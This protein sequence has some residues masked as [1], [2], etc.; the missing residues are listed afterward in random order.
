[1]NGNSNPLSAKH[2]IIV[3]FDF[4]PNFGIGGRR[5]GKLAKGFAQRGIHVH[6]VKAQ[7]KDNRLSTWS[8]DV[9]SP[10]IETLDIRRKAEL[11][12][13]NCQVPIL[14][15]LFYRLAL[16]LN[17]VKEKG[18]PY[19]LAIGS[20]AELFKT[21]DHYVNSYPV[22]WIFVSGAPFNL[23]YYV[24]EYVKQRSNLRM[25]ADFR[26]PWIK[27]KNYGMPGLSD[28]RRE[29]EHRKAKHV[30]QIADVVSYPY[31]EAA[32][33]MTELG[34]DASKLFELKH[35]FDPE[36]TLIEIP[37]RTDNR[38]KLVYGGDIY[39]DSEM[40]L[41]FLASALSTLKTSNRPLYD[42]LDIRIYSSAFHKL[43]QRFS[44]FK[45]IV[46][47][48]D[49]IGK[50]IFQEIGSADWVIVLL[51][52]YN[53][54]FFTTKYFEY[55]PFK[56]PMLYIGPEGKVSKSITHMKQGLML[57]DFLMLLQNGEL[58][59]FK[60]DLSVNPDSGSLQERIDDILKKTGIIT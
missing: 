7:S 19:D 40:H 33:E 48:Q 15:K 52:E 54:D 46:L 59:E 12:R 2:I 11:D 13:F 8:E 18:T 55:L 30:F 36:D 17:R 41:G 49:S 51:S 23:V 34:M 47:L 20:R 5:W 22:E 9:K 50:R 1:M 28:E 57:N 3:N 60:V 53:K 43:T 25:W 21:L 10:L 42:Q 6:V 32:F 39:P 38:I 26:D 37:V 14:N 24:S 58:S 4:P 44:E 27:A 56:K 31:A 35:F 29:E 16:A 45:D